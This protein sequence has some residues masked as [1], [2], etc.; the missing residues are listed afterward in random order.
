MM[1]RILISNTKF[2]H[3]IAPYLQGDFFIVEREFGGIAATKKLNF[4]RRTFKHPIVLV[5]Y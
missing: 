4:A 3:H 5:T 2:I 1:K